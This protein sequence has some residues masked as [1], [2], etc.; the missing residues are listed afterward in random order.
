MRDKRSS[1]IRQLFSGWSTA[2]G[3][4]RALD[5]PVSMYPCNLWIKGEGVPTWQHKVHESLTCPSQSLTAIFCQ[6]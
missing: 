1:E 3:K 2:G 6:Q 4:P 5:F